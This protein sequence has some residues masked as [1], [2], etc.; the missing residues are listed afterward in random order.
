MKVALC[1]SVLRTA[2]VLCGF[3]FVFFC[4]GGVHAKKCDAEG[5]SNLQIFLL[6]VQ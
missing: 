2:V 4:G 3:L 5:L 1:V 6:S